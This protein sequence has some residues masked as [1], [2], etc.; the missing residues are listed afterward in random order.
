MQKDKHLCFQETSDNIKKDKYQNKDKQVAI[1]Q[2]ALQEKAITKLH[3]LDGTTCTRSSACQPSTLLPHKIC[4]IP[5]FTI[6]K[7]TANDKLS[8]LFNERLRT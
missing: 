4:I 6:K 5:T 2:K 7:D 8:K 3:C 1:G